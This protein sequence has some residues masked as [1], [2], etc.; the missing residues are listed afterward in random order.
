MKTKT[1]IIMA[2]LALLAMSWKRGTL[3]D[4][5]KRE[6]IENRIGKSEVGK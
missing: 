1:L 4:V 2:G 3:S 5:I 6:I